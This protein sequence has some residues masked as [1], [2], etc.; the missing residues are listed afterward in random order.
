MARAAREKM[1]EQFSIERMVNAYLDMYT[2][3]IEKSGQGKR[4]RRFS[5]KSH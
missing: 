5:W 2:R 3:T 1:N 4:Q